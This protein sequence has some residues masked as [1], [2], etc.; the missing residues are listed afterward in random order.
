MYAQTGY[1][2][3]TVALAARDEPE[4]DPAYEDP[5]GL[6]D[7]E[8]EPEEDRDAPDLGVA[9]G[10]DPTVPY[11]YCPDWPHRYPCD[12]CGGGGCRQ[13]GGTGE[14]ADERPCRHPIDGSA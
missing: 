7:D 12:Y 5:D 1:G 2:Y 6:L 3:A 13:C 8:P 14:R 10:E 11:T 4:W 9:L